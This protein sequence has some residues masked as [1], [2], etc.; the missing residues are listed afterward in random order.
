MPHR[1]P[2]RAAQYHA[3]YRANLGPNYWRD[4]YRSHKQQ[5]LMTARRSQL[6]TQYGITPE[7][8]MEMVEAQSGLCAICRR[9]EM[10]LYPDG[11]PK[12]LAVDHNHETGVVRGLLC[13]ACNVGIGNLGDDAA[14]VAAAARYLEAGGWPRE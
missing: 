12:S 3:E 6:W 5:R 1:D 8:Y 10:D 14:L 2:E 11:G 13:R 9:P 4:Y 7:Q